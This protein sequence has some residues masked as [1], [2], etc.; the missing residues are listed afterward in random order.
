[1]GNRKNNNQSEKNTKIK[2]KPLNITKYFNY[3]PNIFFQLHRKRLKIIYF[4]E[5][6]K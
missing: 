5:F 4:L 3:V 1:M 6:S 2:Y